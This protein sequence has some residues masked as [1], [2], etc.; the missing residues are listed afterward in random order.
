MAPSIRVVRQGLVVGIIAFGAVALFYAVLDLLAARGALYTVNLLGKSVWR[1]VR[2]PGILVLPI[3]L[4]YVAIAAYSG[5]HL[6]ASLLI[7]L[8]VTRFAAQA[9]R[10]P[11]QAPLMTA[12][13]VGGFVV[14][15]IVVGLLTNSIRPL[16]PWWSIMA[17]NSFAVLAAA[18][19]LA[20]KNP[21]IWQRTFAAGR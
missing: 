19:Y 12:L 9:E 5:L 6:A 14:T 3:Q 15:V 1:G 2:D 10:Q 20:S 11:A 17:A 16:L 7:G 8:I 18:W 4:D 13:I 21:G